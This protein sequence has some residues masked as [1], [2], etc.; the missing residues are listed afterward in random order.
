MKPH[1]PSEDGMPQT[2]AAREWLRLDMLPQGDMILTARLLFVFICLAMLATNGW[3]IY[4]N[5]VHQIVEV[6]QS[7]SNLARAVTQQMEG[8]ISEVDHILAGIVFE[9]ERSDLAPAVL[10]RLQPVLVNHVASVEQLHGLSVYD[11]HGRR[12]LASDP[13]W[14]RWHSSA[15]RDYFNRHRES[16]GTRAY[17]GLPIVSRTSGEWVIPVSRRTTDA[18][19]NFAGVVVAALSIKHLHGLLNHFDIGKDGAVL[20]VMADRILVRRPFRES[21][22]G[23]RTPASPLKTLFASRRAGTVDARSTLDGV[24]RIIS[25][26]HLTNYPILVTVGASR[27]EAL[28]D[29]FVASLFQTGWVAFLCLVVGTTGRYVIRLMRLRVSVEAGLR[30]ARDALTVANERLT[31]LA[32]YDGL[33]GLPN[34]RYFDARLARAFRQAVEASQP[35]AIAMVDVDEF[36][37]YNDLYGHLEGDQ[38]LRRVADALR[39]AANRPEDFV[40][41]YGG[42]EMVLLM[43]RT[44]AA[45]AAS[46]AEAARAAV[47]RL[48]IPHAASASG[49]VSVSLGVAAAQPQA[50]GTSHALLETADRALYQAKREG[51][52]RVVQQQE[53]IAV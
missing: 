36:K 49:H 25:F 13:L 51:R 42:E 17:I 31:H 10:E 21:D 34:R 29:W 39:S 8:V 41:R 4:R 16:Q 43:P 2:A 47:A 27:A 3:L 38:C 7:T 5:R 50:D 46:V 33:T 19:G 24:A 20:L 32:Q 45:T 52:N 11:A 53:P 22:L 48:R 1:H 15:D 28:D 30:E 37:Q 40:A 44:D 14:D 12:I 9:L 23:A 26:D 35:I 6:S 18:F